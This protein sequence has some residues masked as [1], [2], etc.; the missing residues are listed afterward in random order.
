MED[1]TKIPVWIPKLF[2]RMLLA[3][4]FL[5]Y[6][7]WLITFGFEFWNDVGVYSVTIVLVCFG[8]VGNWLY[9]EI[10]KKELEEADEA[11]H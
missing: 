9:T 11:N 6:F 4:G 3:G 1:S 10:E 2:Y 8:F 5:F 7:G